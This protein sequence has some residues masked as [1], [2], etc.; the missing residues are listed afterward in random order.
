MTTDEAR[1]HVTQGGDCIA[2]LLLYKVT[3][4]RATFERAASYKE[5]SVQPITPHTTNGQS[6]SPTEA[7][8]QQKT[9]DTIICA[10][11]VVVSNKAQ[12]W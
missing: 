12:N 11:V 10:T 6:S 2:L 8:W 3:L 7:S 9:E 1:D 5:A 4:R